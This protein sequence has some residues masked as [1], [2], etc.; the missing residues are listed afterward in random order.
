MARQAASMRIHDTRGDRIFNAVNIAFTLLCVAL[1]VYPLYFIIVA[2]FSDPSLVALGKVVIIPK[3]ITFDGYGRI[4]A[5]RELWTGYRNTVVYTALGTLFNLFLTLTAGFALSRKEMPF[6]RIVMAVFTV[7]MFISGGLVPTF[8]LVKNTLKL[9]N[10]FFVMIL[11]SGLSVY[12]MI[13]CRT[14]FENTIPE[15]LWD[16][17]QVDGCNE[18]RYFVSIVLPLSGA[19][20]AVL[21]LYYAVGHWNSYFNA[22]IYLR[23]KNLFS[24]QLVLRNI[25]IANQYTDDMASL[26][27]GADTTLKLQTMKYA[28]IVVSTV[29][30][31]IV[32]PFVQKHFV[33]G[34]M[35]GAVKG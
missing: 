30:M 9:Y 26:D 32:Y 14:F 33:K 8:L 17:V 4:M 5:N 29:P 31:L 10:T 7:T 28:I 20:V 2:S 21:A 3:G 24:L 6:R 11:L 1:C 12:N 18:F 25:L 27:V 15:D 23:D 16:A 35:I 19:V 22:M 34:V 13:I